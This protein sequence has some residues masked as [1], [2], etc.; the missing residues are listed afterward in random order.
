M[1]KN[2][3]ILALAL[4]CSLVVLSGAVNANAQIVAMSDSDLSEITGQA[5]FATMGSYAGFQRDAASNSL[6]FGGN[7]AT[8]SFNDPSYQMERTGEV[9]A[10][11]ISEDGSSFSFDIKNP[12]FTIRNY[13]T[14]LCI[15]N[16]EG[17]GNSLG[18]VSMGLIRVTTHGTVRV[19]VR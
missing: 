10:I 14:S 6:H 5:G 15:G 11:R 4:I 16:Q 17:T 2:H 9:S 18:T 13:Q 8:L 12:G 3:L 1:K 19:T 7:G